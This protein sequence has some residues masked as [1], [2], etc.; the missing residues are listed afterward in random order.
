MR[1]AGPAEVEAARAD[2]PGDA[3]YPSRSGAT[4][5]SGLAAALEADGRP[6]ASTRGSGHRTG[7]W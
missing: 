5:P 6:V 1:G 3:A 4:V 2:G 7:T